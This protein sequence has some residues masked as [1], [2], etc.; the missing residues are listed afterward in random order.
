[1]SNFKVTF[2]DGNHLVTGMNATLE[3]AQAYY[4]GKYF[5]FGDRDWGDPDRMVRA[6]KVEQIL[7]E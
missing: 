3:E 7:G 1:M 4:V 2:E 6:V 5:N